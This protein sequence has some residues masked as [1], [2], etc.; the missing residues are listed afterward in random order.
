[1]KTL[2][3]YIENELCFFISTD[4]KEKLLLKV[5]KRNFDIVEKTHSSDPQESLEFEMKRQKE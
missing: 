4:F 2:F 3:Y 5:A 1:M